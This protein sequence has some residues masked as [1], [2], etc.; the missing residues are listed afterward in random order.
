M[1][2]C[3]GGM[4]GPQAAGWSYIGRA[5]VPLPLA[6][7]RGMH[8]FGLAKSAHILSAWMLAVALAAHTHLS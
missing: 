5:L 2:E 6:R 3:S 4:I 8:D 1:G 7:R